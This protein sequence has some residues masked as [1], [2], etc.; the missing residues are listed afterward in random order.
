VFGRKISVGNDLYEKLKK[1]SETAGYATPEEFATHVL[2]K[3][4]ERMLFGSVG[5]SDEEISKNT[6]QGLGDVG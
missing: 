2:E 6:V 3:E 4:A 1:C 5:K